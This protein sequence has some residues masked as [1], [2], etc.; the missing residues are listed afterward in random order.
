[1]RVTEIAAYVE[2]DAGKRGGLRSGAF[3]MAMGEVERPVP[4]VPAAIV[5]LMVGALSELVS[6]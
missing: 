1:M 4:D 3:R 6:G 2:V 5:C